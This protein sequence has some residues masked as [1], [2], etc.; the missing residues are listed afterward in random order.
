MAKYNLL[1]YLL[2]CTYSK[3]PPITFNYRNYNKFNGDDFR[4]EL[5]E[6]LSIYNQNFNFGI[7]NT[8]FSK[9]L[10]TCAPIK[11]KTIRGNHKPFVSKFLKKEMMKRAHLKNIANKSGLE[12]GIHA[13]K[14]QHN[15]V[16]S[17]N[18]KAKRDFFSSIKIKKDAKSFWHA[19][20]PFMASKP[21]NN[22]ET[23][24]LIENDVVLTEDNKVADVFNNYVTY[25]TKTLDIPSWRHHDIY[26]N[27]L[28]IYAI[29]KHRYH[30][31]IMSIKKSSHMLIEND[32]V[33]TEDNKV[34]DVFNNY[35]TYITKTLDIPSWRHHD[36]YVNDLIIY[37]IS[38]YR[39]HHS[40]MSIKK[41][42]PK[43]K[44]TFSHVSSETV[45]KYIIDLIK[46]SVDTPLKIL[47]FNADIITPFLTNCINYSLENNCFHEEL[48]LA[49]I[50]PI[51]K[52]VIVMTRATIDLSVYSLQ[53]PKFSK[54]LF[55]TK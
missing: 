55:L 41:S 36:I 53:Y 1:T 19:C 12:S 42:S 2:R 38:K 18:K 23:I 5:K 11:Q 17:L 22:K 16:V 32:V 14:H 29:S 54:K 47:K 50:I 39:Y 35:F 9:I 30:H 15:L 46:G 45:Y 34:A 3:L 51:H 37:A 25:I 4:N 33:L 43:T 6:Q 49:D 21:I 7:F 8:I 10:N 27:D 24:M 48:K 28:I 31:S 20:K 40:I 44:F 52:K 26:V 13:Y